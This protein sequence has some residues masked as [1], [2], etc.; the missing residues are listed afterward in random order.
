MARLPQ[1]MRRTPNGK[2]ELRFSYN[3]KRYSVTGIDVPGVLEAERKKI[4]EL[5]NTSYVLNKD[6][7]LKDYYKEYLKVWR[8]TVKPASYSNFVNV[9]EKHILP[10]LGKTK[11]K[12]LEIRQIQKFYDDLIDIDGLGVAT[13][14]VYLQHVSKMLREAVHEGI[15]NKNPCERVRKRKRTEKEAIETFHRALSREEQEL[16]E[17]VIVG[18]WYEWLLR[19]MLYSGCRV[20]EVLALRWSDVDFQNGT[21]SI[22]R[23]ITRDQNGN[24]VIGDSPKTKAGVREIPM[25]GTLKKCLLEQRKRNFEIHGKVG[26]EDIVF[27]SKIAG[28]VID[29]KQIDYAIKCALRKMPGVEKFTSHALRDT[30]ATRFLE[31][32]GNMKTLQV[33]LGHASFQMTS[34]LYA[35]VMPDTKAEEME[36]ME[37]RMKGGD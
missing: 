32:G 29:S 19:V 3:G 26:K 18:S 28:N 15:I 30:F 7:Q 4:E 33:L 20:G 34:D 16:F 21:I 2:I 10:E 24:P 35:H 17:S 5:V 13:A 31:S 9:A 23:T 14:G 27:L 8:H 36:R 25:T 1:G 37:K 12:D 6:I 22:K 11:V